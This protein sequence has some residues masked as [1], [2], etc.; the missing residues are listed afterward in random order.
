MPTIVGR[1]SP[2]RR[3]AR[4]CTSPPSP[5]GRTSTARPP[6]ERCSRGWRPPP[7]RS[8]ARTTRT[9]CS[10]PTCCSC[11]TTSSRR[12]GTFT[13]SSAAGTWVRPAGRA[14]AKAP[15]GSASGPSGGTP[16]TPSAR[17]LH[18][19]APV[20]TAAASRTPPPA[21]SR[22]RP[23]SGAA[24]RR[25]P[26]ESRAR[27]KTRSRCCRL[28]PWAS[29]RSTSRKASLHHL[30]ATPRRTLGADSRPRGSGRGRRRCLTC[31]A[32]S[33][34][35]RPRSSAGPGAPSA[36]RP[37]ARTSTPSSSRPRAPCRASA[38]PCGASAS[39]RTG[40]PL[41]TAHQSSRTGA[42]TCPRTSSCCYA[43]T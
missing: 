27:C 5:R 40:T 4:R 38:P 30:R 1:G 11:W 17:R 26:L 14:G 41:P 9:T 25:A 33:S 6:L 36:R 43:R 3:S 28:L 8:L 24:A 15:C 42:I 10:M 34:L 12:S 18:W 23:P 22:R 21:A 31:R 35:P 16:R 32:P 2:M 7:R 29:S 37:E 39:P 13:A 20:E 19:G